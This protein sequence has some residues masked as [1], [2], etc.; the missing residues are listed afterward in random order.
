MNR[1]QSLILIAGL[2]FATLVVFLPRQLSFASEQGSQSYYLHL[3]VPLPTQI[4][5]LKVVTPPKSKRFLLLARR[6]SGA[7]ERCESCRKYVAFT[8]GYLLV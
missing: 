1:P 5:L 6:R 7:G 8:A 4:F 2:V 3:G